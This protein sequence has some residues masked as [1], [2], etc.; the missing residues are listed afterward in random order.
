MKRVD[1]WESEDGAQEW[2]RQSR[3]TAEASARI[4]FLLFIVLGALAA[5]A[6]TRG[7]A[8]RQILDTLCTMNYPECVL[9][10]DR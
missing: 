6:Y 4:V 3:P 5:A 10:V 2:A 1:R 9:G 7:G 8:H